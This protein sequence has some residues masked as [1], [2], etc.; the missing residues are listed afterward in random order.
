MTFRQKPVAVKQVPE[1]LDWKRG[2]A[3]YRE[4]DS[5][6]N[7]ERPCIVLDCSRVEQ[8][9]EQT[10]FLLLCCLEGAMKRNGDVRLA[11]VTPHAQEKLAIAEA[12]RLFRIFETT[13]DAIDSFQRRSATS[14]ASIDLHRTAANA[15]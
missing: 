11:R 8:M 13:E 15:A 9:D 3:F 10:I 6:M 7:V 1:K 2:R 12:D 4:L 5:S 14:P